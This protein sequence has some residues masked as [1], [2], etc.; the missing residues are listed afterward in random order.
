M[1]IITLDS[2]VKNSSLNLVTVINSL[3]KLS[4]LILV[5]F[6]KIFSRKEGET[7]TQ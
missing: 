2:A 3:Q 6:T 5:Q 1:L 7:I 4:V